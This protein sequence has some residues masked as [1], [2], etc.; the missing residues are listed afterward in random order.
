LE[1][2]KDMFQDGLACWSNN[3]GGK[4]GGMGQ[5]WDMRSWEAAEWFV[6]K[7]SGLVDRVV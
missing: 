3:G 2:K 7:W 1:L 4:E 6:R 5:P